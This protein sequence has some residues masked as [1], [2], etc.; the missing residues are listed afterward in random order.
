MSPGWNKHT[1]L[2]WPFPAPMGG[3]GWVLIKH[4]GGVHPCVTLRV[5]ICIVAVS[6]CN[7]KSTGSRVPL[8]AL[9]GGLYGQHR[10]DAGGAAVSKQARLKGLTGLP[11][12]R[13]GDTQPTEECGRQVLRVTVT[14]RGREGSTQV[15]GQGY[16]TLSTDV[17][18]MQAPTGTNTLAHA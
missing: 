16:V 1:R 14:T 18:H 7:G 12:P 3:R 4:R 11:V 2:P 5:A 13:G 9:T 17:Q 10:A 8:P 15:R 6:T